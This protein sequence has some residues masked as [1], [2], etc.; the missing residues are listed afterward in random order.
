M[1]QVLKLALNLHTLHVVF[2]GLSAAHV[3]VHEFCE[4]SMRWQERYLES[5]C[6]YCERKR[7]ERTID[8]KI[9]I[10]R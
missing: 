10:Q 5:S 7:R 9:A 3:Q 6:E 8:R 2:V 1:V 4:S